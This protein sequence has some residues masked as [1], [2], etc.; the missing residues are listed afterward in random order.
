MGEAACRWVYEFGEFR[1]D[2]CRRVLSVGADG[3]RIQV[4]PKV[5]DAAFY[6]VQ[7]LNH[8]TEH[9]TQIKT[10]LTQAGINPPELDGWT[11]DDERREQTR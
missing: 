11:W 8:A 10:A 3:A 4:A 9:R 7:A 6:F 2:A 5:F 1:L